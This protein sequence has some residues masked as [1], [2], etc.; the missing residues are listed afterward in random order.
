MRL[1][2]GV[3]GVL[4][5]LAAV[6]VLASKQVDATRVTVPVVQPVPGASAPA[7]GDSEAAVRAQG[8]QVQRQI[9][10]QVESL[11]QQPRPM[12]DEDSK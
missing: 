9:Q 5:A 8:Q 2:W 4:A 6:A 11:M 3:A 7:Q 1:G 12:P 10:Q